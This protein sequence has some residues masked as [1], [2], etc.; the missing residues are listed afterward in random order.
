MIGTNVPQDVKKQ[1]VSMIE[2]TAV[3]KKLGTF[4]TYF[5]LLKG[6]VSIGILYMPKNSLNGGWAFTLGTMIISFFI[7]YYCIIKLLQAR[8]KL[9]GLN[10]FADIAHAAMGPFG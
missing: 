1:V 8:D 9:G 3:T 5:S 6:F 10:S 2:V 7:T 4:E